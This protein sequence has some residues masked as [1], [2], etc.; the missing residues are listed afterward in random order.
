MT[1]S[2]SYEEKRPSPWN[3]WDAL[4]F[5]A[6]A[7]LVT[8][9]AIYAQVNGIE[10]HPRA[11]V[12]MWVVT[13]AF[14]SV[15]LLLVR[16]RSKFIES[17]D[18]VL[19]TGMMVQTNGYKISRTEFETE[20]RRVCSLWFP[21]YPRAQEFLE[22][23]RIWVRFESKILEKR[24]FSR[25]T[26]RTFAGLTSMG[27]ESIRLTYFEDPLKQLEQTAFAHE[28]GHVILGRATNSWDNDQ[29]H[30]FMQ[31]RKLP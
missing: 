7:A 12:H 31:E 20:L 16:A 23:S 30:K 10:G 3:L 21:H 9:V 22:Q 28:L 24:A 27:G 6:I 15:Y 1:R 29:H 18:L 2:D 8:C 14:W 11:Y 19:S 13:A 26:P 25:S 4:T 17:Y 5:G